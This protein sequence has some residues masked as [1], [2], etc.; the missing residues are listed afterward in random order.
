MSKACMISTASGRWPR[1]I[2]FLS[3]FAATR[4]R[5]VESSSPPPII[6]PVTCGS[7]SRA[8]DEG[9]YVF[10]FVKAADEADYECFFRDVEFFPYLCAAAGVV[11]GRD[12]VIDGFDFFGG[13]PGVVD[14][15]VSDGVGYGDAAAGEAVQEA[16]FG[17]PPGV[18][19]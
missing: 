6:T 15:V 4:A 11:R 2:M 10:L 12:S 19:K 16:E 7:F 9:V 18:A 3:C 1:N 13:E 5:R 17:A 8:R 14:E